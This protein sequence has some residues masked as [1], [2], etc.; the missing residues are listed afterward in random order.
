MSKKAM[1]K[2]KLSG[3]VIISYADLQSFAC[4]IINSNSVGLYLV[5]AFLYPC[6]ING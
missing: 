1:S 5:I 3:F 4:S 6:I 2:T